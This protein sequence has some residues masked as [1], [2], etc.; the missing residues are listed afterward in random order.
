MA[1]CERLLPSPVPICLS[2]ADDRLSPEQRQQVERL[3]KKVAKEA[4]EALKEKMSKEMLTISKNCLGQLFKT[5]YTRRSF[6]TSTVD[7]KAVG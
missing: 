4:C 1:V 5:L 3:A 7:G 2:E 6:W